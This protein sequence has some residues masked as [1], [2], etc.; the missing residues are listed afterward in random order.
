[1][2]IGSNTRVF[3]DLSQLIGYANYDQTITGAGER[4]IT[5]WYTSTSWHGGVRW[6][7]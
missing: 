6:M 7:Y 3:G 4:K 5:G 2:K 1:M